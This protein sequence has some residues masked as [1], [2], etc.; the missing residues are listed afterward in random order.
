MYNT[1]YSE[2]ERLCSEKGREKVALEGY[3]YRFDKNSK[4]D[5]DT[6]FWRC[7]QKSCLARI[8]TN[9]ENVTRRLGEHTHGPN[10]P[11]VDAAKIVSA[12][13]ERATNSRDAARQILS[14]AL[15]NVESNV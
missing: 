3:I 14:E 1:F 15:E 2:M 4:L 6:K 5:A 10:V 8:H 11:K 13:K 12:L 9:G 7:E